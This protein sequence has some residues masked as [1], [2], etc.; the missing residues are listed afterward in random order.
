MARSSRSADFLA[1]IRYKAVH[2]Q[3]FE[4]V[5]EWHRLFVPAFS[6]ARKVLEIFHKLFVFSNWKNHGSLLTSIV[7]DILNGLGHDKELVEFAAIVEPFV[8]AFSIIW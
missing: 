4:H 7:G 6:D 8:K 3:S 5:L 1:V 2:F